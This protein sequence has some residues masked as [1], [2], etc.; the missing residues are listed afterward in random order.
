[1]IFQLVMTACVAFIDLFDD[2]PFVITK[3]SL[4]FCRVKTWGFSSLF[5]E[6][7]WLHVIGVILLSFLFFFKFVSVHMDHITIN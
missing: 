3:T 2:S 4:F 1:M 5:V 7:G 6:Y